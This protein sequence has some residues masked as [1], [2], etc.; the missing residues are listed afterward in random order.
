MNYKKLAL[1]LPLLP[2]LMANSPARSS[3]YSEYEDFE[4]SYVREDVI[5]N[6]RYQ[7]FHLNNKGQGYIS[8]FTVLGAE[9]YDFSLYFHDYNFHP[10]FQNTVIAP[11]QEIDLSGLAYTPLATIDGSKLK[12]ACNAYTSL[13]QSLT[14]TGDKSVSLIQKRETYCYYQLNVGIDG[15][16]SENKYGI[17]VNAAYEGQEFYLKVDSYEKY[18]F[19]TSESIDLSK[20]EIKDVAAVVDQSYQ[21]D[22]N[23]FSPVIDFLVRLLIIFSLVVLIVGGL[24]FLLIFLPKI[25]RKSNERKRANANREQNK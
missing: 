18:R 5:D 9:D 15:A 23:G 20:L 11:G 17:I 13:N 12:Y 24:I 1:L 22:Y 21:I 6:Y 2:L 3:Y 8:S 19:Y 25:V 16:S 10:I 7:V 4:A 14:V